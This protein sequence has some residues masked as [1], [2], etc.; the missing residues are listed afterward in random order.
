MAP[1]LE[2]EDLHAAVDET[3]ILHGVSL[4]VASGEIH[5]LM[6]PNGAGK[7]TL[8][9]VIMGH[10][11]YRITRGRIALSGEDISLWPPDIRAKAGV[12]LAFQ[13]PESIDGVSVV[14]FLR[15][16]VAARKGQDDLSILEVRIA[17]SEWMERLG[18]DPSFAQRHLNQGFSGGERKRNEILQM[19][20]LEP[21]VAVLD[22]TDSGLDIDALRTVGRGVNL[23]KES[24]QEMGV[25][26]VTHYQAILEYLQPDHVHI[27]VDGKVVA[28]GGPELSLEVQEYGYD[29][30]R[31]DGG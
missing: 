13:Y 19:A 11:A 5:A 30:W 25:V 29:R 18:M 24:N 4:S 2:I 28:S 31:D 1:L 16:A 14:Q 7:S 21:R 26:V 6:G 17:M 20:L 27:L 12:F 9:A 23:V 10:P 15:Q 8:A 3:E 22:E